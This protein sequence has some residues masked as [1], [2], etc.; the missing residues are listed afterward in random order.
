R[1]GYLEWLSKD[2][3]FSDKLER[4]NFLIDKVVTDYD[5]LSEFLDFAA[6][7][8]N[9]DD[10]NTGNFVSLMTI[11][12]AKGLEFD[13]VFLPAWEENLFPNKKTLGSLE[14]EEE[15]RLA[16]VAITRAKKI[17]VIS[18]VASRWLFNEAQYNPPSRFITEID[19]RYLD[20]QGGA[21]RARNYYAPTP[22]AYDVPPK[23]R[24]VPIQ[25]N[26]LKGKFVSHDEL[27]DGVVIDDDGNILTVAFKNKGIKKVARQFVK[28]N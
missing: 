3:N 26:T 13:T 19:N 28:I 22:R 15:R 20:F 2:D 4:I 8:T 5:S 6:L 25:N 9:E 7:K 14:I 11:H 1:S 27:G 17:C 24:P 21:P 18:C 12:A 23:P 16:Y 10:E